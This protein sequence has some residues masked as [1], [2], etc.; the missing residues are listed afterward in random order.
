MSEQKKPWPKLTEYSDPERMSSEFMNFQL[1]FKDRLDLDNLQYMVE[2][3]YEPVER[4]EEDH[5]G[6][7]RRV[8]TLDGVHQYGAGLSGA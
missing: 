3:G 6:G 2:D 1:Q 4:P 5:V 7:I 8:A